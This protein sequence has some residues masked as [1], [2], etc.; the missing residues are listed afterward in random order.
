MEEQRSQ[1][2]LVNST[3]PLPKGLIYE[4][5][6][7]TDGMLPTHLQKKQFPS[8]LLAHLN[9]EPT[10]PLF[11]LIKT[12]TNGEGVIKD[13][14]IIR[15]LENSLYEGALYP[16]RDPDT[17]RGDEGTMLKILHAFWGAVKMVFQ[18]AWGLPPKRSRLMHGAGIVSLGFIMDDIAALLS[19]DEL[20]QVTAFAS[21]LQPLKEACY[22][23]SGSWPFGEGHFM[24]WDDLQN[25]SKHTQLLANYL[26]IEF[27]KRVLKRGTQG[28]VA[29]LTVG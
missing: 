2:I 13:N 10:S 7:V 29:S 21:K 3:K 6:P 16:Y 18:E 27:R 4:L 12:P 19:R 26:R 28:V 1:F 23:T 25:T 15:M 20:F 11:K 24:K 8:A 14:S 22:W 9:F 17:G 5:L